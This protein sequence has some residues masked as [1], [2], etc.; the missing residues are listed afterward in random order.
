MSRLYKLTLSYDGTSYFGWQKTKTGPS[1]Q[2]TLELAVRQVT[3]EEILPEGASRTDR[4]VHAS[5]QVASIQL[6]RAWEPNAL[7][8]ALNAVLPQD[9]RIQLIENASLEFHPTLNA[10]EKEYH[11]RLCMGDVQDPINRL[12]SWAF[13]YPLDIEKMIRAS[14]DFLGMHDF[15]AFANEEKENPFCTIS[16]IEIAS[17]AFD[18]LQIAIT[19]NRFLYK[20]ARNIAGTLIYIGCGKIDEHAIPKI[21]ESKDRKQAGISAPAHG[22]F[23][24]KVRYLGDS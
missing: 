6:Q 14:K 23:L 22:L 24:H 5:G 21:F 8:R 19:G 1:V 11:Y 18:R 10:I 7:L 12:Y 20:M 13:H 2:E 17:L 3:Q 4:G 16:R 15:S 9:I